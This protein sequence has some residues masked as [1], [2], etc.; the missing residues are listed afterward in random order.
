[1]KSL[2]APSSAR[3]GAES[4]AAV[5]ATVIG[6]PAGAVSPGGKAAVT[7]REVAPESSSKA[8]GE[9][10]RAMAVSSSKMMSGAAGTTL[11][12]GAEPENTTAS[13]PSRLRSFTSDKVRL[14]EALLCPAGMVIV[15]GPV[16]PVPSAKKKSVLGAAELPEVERVTSAAVRNRATLSRKVAVTVSGTGPSFSA[17][18][19]RLTDSTMSSASSSTMVTVGL[20]GARLEV[21]T[22]RTE[23]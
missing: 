6:P 21:V 23:V 20:P 18:D 8:A 17:A 19:E 3:P 7:V 16:P 13:D 15:K 9:T 10:D 22:E 4:P 14:A 2:S 11:K 12:V 1:M 5:R